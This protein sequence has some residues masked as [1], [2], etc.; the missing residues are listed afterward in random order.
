M[1]SQGVLPNNPCSRRRYVLSY[2]SMPMSFSSLP[3]PRFFFFTRCLPQLSC[4]THSLPQCEQHSVYSTQYPLAY[5]KDRP[6]RPP[7]WWEIL[8]K[9]RSDIYLVQT[10][11]AATNAGASSPC[12]IWPAISHG[13]IA[14]KSMICCCPASSGDPRARICC[15]GDMRQGAR[16]TLRG[17]VLPSRTS[18]CRRHS[19]TSTPLIL[20]TLDP[21]PVKSERTW[22]VIQ[23]STRKSTPRLVFKSSL[24]PAPVPSSPHYPPTL[25]LPQVGCSSW[26]QSAI[27]SSSVAKKN[28]DI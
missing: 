22:H 11:E 7:V 21:E 23:T 24:P 5:T 9:F 16:K 4:C 8:F 6:P 12:N 1:S 19:R 18:T 26:Q 20:P 10:L 2:F 27:P 17:G 3:C 15:V 13:S 14:T 25:S 28:L